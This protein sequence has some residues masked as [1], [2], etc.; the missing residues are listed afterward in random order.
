M[1]PE[2][3]FTQG[4]AV[5]QAVQHGR[6][7]PLAERKDHDRTRAPRQSAG[8]GRGARIAS[9]P[10]GGVGGLQH[11]E[12]EGE[13]RHKTSATAQGKT[14]EHGERQNGYEREPRQRPDAAHEDHVLVEESV[15]GC[16]RTQGEDDGHH[17]PDDGEDPEPSRRH[18]EPHEAEDENAHPREQGVLHAIGRDVPLGDGAEE[19]G[20]AGRVRLQGRGVSRHLRHVELHPLELPH[21]QVGRHQGHEKHG[22]K[23]ETHHRPSGVPKPQPADHGEQQGD[24]QGCGGDGA[25]IHGGEALQTQ[26]EAHEECPAPSGPLEVAIEGEERKGQEERHL[27]MQM[28]QARPTV[29]TRSE[30]GPG[31]RRR[32]TGPRSHASRYARRPGRTGRSSRGGPDCMRAPAVP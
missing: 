14:C 10:D 4:S 21:A 15:D 19:P 18:H 32:P 17:S 3:P 9:P 6:G 1:K 30:E 7:I 13:N 24:S 2:S 25:E 16:G 31:R 8:R 26:E 12:G 22:G 23:P 5:G 11:H 20:P 28:G 29:G 27:G